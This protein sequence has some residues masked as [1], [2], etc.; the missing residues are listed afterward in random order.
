M[1]LFLFGLMM[2]VFKFSRLIYI[3]IGF[4]FLVLGC[5]FLYCF[6]LGEFMFFYFICLCV[7]SSI[8]GLLM[9]VGS[10]KFFGSDLA[11]F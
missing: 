8:F 5:F 10:M 2:I 9:M 1:Y 6:V 7:M 3:L 11:Y 4:G